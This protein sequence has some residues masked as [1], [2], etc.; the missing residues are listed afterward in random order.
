M[1]SHFFIVGMD[2]GFPLLHYKIHQDDDNINAIKRALLPLFFKP[3]TPL[4]QHSII[5]I[6]AKP[7]TSAHPEMAIF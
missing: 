6:E 7:L 5:P 1:I 2:T 3:I 4:F